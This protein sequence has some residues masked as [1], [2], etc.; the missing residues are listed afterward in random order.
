MNGSKSKDERLHLLD[1]LDKIIFVSKWVQD[2]FFND[3][4]K[5]LINK[6]E[7]VYPSIHRVKKKIILFPKLKLQQFGFVIF[8]NIQNSKKQI[9]FMETL[10]QKI[11]LQKIM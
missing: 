1:N 5:K 11:I 9:L 2:R 6:T 10:N 7:I 3:L 4:D 8:T